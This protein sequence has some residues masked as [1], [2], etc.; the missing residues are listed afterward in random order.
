MKRYLNVENATLEVNFDSINKYCELLENNINFIKKQNFQRIIFH[1]LEKQIEKMYSL[2]E[3]YF[4]NTNILI[5]FYTNLSKTFKLTKNDNI[6]IV[7]QKND[8]IVSM[9]NVYNLMI[10]DDNSIDSITFEINK[11]SSII[12]EP[13]IDINNI[14]SF[15]NNINLLFSKLD[16]K[17][18]NLN[19]YLIPTFL[20][21]EHPCNA[22]LC[23][24]WKCGKK[25]SCLP[26]Y[27]SI[28]NNGNLYPHNLFYK[29]LLIGNIYENDFNSLIEK[30]YSSKEYNNFINYSRN[31]FIKYL[32]NY[33]YEYMPLIEFIRK[34]AE[35]DK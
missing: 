6:M 30:Y 35:D 23:N 5:I 10:L 32:A 25:I 1:V 21:R 27:I 15:V 14:S 7:N 13:K 31:V 29:K 34:E 33:P 11:N 3:K 24:G 2:I 16:N 8:N 28:T 20:M 26:K 12:V 9:D 18:I 17:D 4:G 19:G 22:Y